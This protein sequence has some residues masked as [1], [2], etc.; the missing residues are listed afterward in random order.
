MKY[1]I[2]VILL[3]TKLNGQIDNLTSQELQHKIELDT[4]VKL[5][6]NYFKVSAF[7]LVGGVLLK[8]I[9]K[10]WAILGASSS[11]AASGTTT[12]YLA[13]HLLYVSKRN[14]F[15]KKHNLNFRI[16]GKR[17]EKDHS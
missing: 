14:R 1:L 12:Y 4:K 9:N 10:N 17:K 15:Y 8:S 6:K 3:S 16:K 7:V 11:L 13:K 2:I 5:S